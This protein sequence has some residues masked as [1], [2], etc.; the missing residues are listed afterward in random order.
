MVPGAGC[1]VLHPLGVQ[2]KSTNKYEQQQQ[3]R[4]QQQAEPK[5]TT[6]A[7]TVEQEGQNKS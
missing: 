4:Q 3:Q 1:L 5:Q 2:I 6:M 7:R